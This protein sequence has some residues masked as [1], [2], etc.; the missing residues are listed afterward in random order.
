M[1]EYRFKRTLRAMLWAAGVAVVLLVLLHVS[2]PYVVNRDGVRTWILAYISRYL[3]GEVHV[4]SL[5][6]GLL[7]CPGLT[8]DQ[9][10][11]TEPGVIDVRIKSG[12][13]RVKWIPL[14]SGRL[15]LKRL[16]VDN[17]ELAFNWPETDADHQRPAAHRPTGGI[18]TSI[19]D[20]AAVLS[21]AIRRATIHIRNARLSVRRQQRPLLGMTFSV[22]TRHLESRDTDYRIE[23]PDLRLFDGPHTLQAKAVQVQGTVLGTPDQLRLAITRLQSDMP[24]FALSGSLT[25]PK[26]SISQGPITIN[27]DNG[28]VDVTS[29][30]ATLRQIAQS[31]PVLQTLFDIVRGGHIASL[32]AS[33]S[34]PTWDAAAHTDNLEVEAEVSEGRIMVPQEL[35]LLNDVRGKVRWSGGRLSA[36]DA[37]ARLGD[38]AARGGTLALG[39]LDGTHA[40]SLDTR[41]SANL[42]ELPP[43]LKKLVRDPSDLALLEKLPALSGHAEGRLILGDR[44]DHIRA[45][46]QT[47]AAVTLLDADVTV[48]GRIED[49][50]SPHGHFN[51]KGK[52]VLGPESM[53]WLGRIGGVSAQWMPQDTLTV[54]K[55]SLARSADGTMEIRTEMHLATDVDLSADLQVRPQAFHL[56]KLHLRDKVSDAIL[57]AYRHSTDST[58]RVAFK[59]LLDVQTVN[60]I[61]PQHRIH[62]GVIDGELQ[63]EVDTAVPE[64]SRV[65]GSFETRGLACQ[66]PFSG[67]VRV[68]SM[69]VSA[70][71][72]AF[73]ISDATVEWRNHTLAVSGSGTY[74]P[75]DTSVDM[76]IVADTLDITPLIHTAHTAASQP[77]EPTGLPDKGRHPIPVRGRIQVDIGDLAVGSYRF[78]PLHAD[79]ELERDQVL[80]D[81]ATANVC[82][83]D[84]PG[85]IRWSN[86]VLA[87][88]V[89]PFA[90]GSDLHDT[91]TCLNNS[92]K[93]EHY[94]GTVDV[95][96]KIATKGGNADQLMANLKGNVSV[97]IR[98]GRVSNI[99]T[100]GLLT[101]IL[102]YMSVNELIEGDLPDLRKENFKYKSIES[103]L[104][105]KKG[106]LH[107]EEGILKSNALNLAAEGVYDLSSDNLKLNVLVSPLTTVDWVIAHVPIVNHILQ[108][109]LVAVPVRVTGP[110]ADPTVVPL[111]PSAVG[112]RVGGI[113]KRILQTPYYIIE[114]ILP[115]KKEDS[116]KTGKKNHIE[117]K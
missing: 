44:L 12:S 117:A 10:H 2:L 90:E 4:E 53:D 65:E 25:L 93:T 62:S 47:K 56:N 114:P 70:Q 33:F 54:A 105:L 96:G 81:I 110:L 67:P 85:Q 88:V 58:W 42:S 84:M 82:G 48:D 3:P 61:F 27:V 49:I 46:I 19:A 37:S 6:P 75:G 31:V 104:K 116:K 89:R 111:S 102:S 80:V 29:L 69:R 92:K 36:V 79:V 39:L 60:K 43:L 16:S 26:P 100:A 106:R 38:S 66:L 7:P 76:Y 51:I 40:F 64:R 68:L 83:V 35:F 15:E 107:I 21:K 55:A 9:G 24:K 28:T 109:T 115:K 30:R 99:G 8:I 11:Y 113:L 112:S 86:G 95:D 94:Q 50:P 14:L 71:N 72:N 22:K 52:G 78:V 23:M 63:A 1:G 108:G 77:T 41:L 34:A 32:R 97:R 87:M 20:A 98:D 5:T 17:P 103:K 73:A 57:S 45:T 101:N 91:G 59:G 13:L 74:S 18:K